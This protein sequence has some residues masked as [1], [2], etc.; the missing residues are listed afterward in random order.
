LAYKLKLK[1]ITIYRYGS[2]EDQVLSLGAEEKGNPTPAGDWIAVNS[3]FA[4]GCISG[5]CPF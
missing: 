1:G 4:G 3:D 2:K 5:V